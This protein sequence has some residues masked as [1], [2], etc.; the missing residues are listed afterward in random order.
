M[1][2]DSPREYRESDDNGLSV[3]AFAQ[4]RAIVT[5]SLMDDA[6]LAAE[7]VEAVTHPDLVMLALA[8]MLTD[9]FRTGPLTD[10]LTDWRDAVSTMLAR[11]VA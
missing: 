2:D 1:N 8:A 5:S 7:Q 3:E 10:P 9:I 4:A 6:G 11:G